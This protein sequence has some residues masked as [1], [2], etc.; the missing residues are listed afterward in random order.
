MSTQFWGVEGIESEMEYGVAARHDREV[1]IKVDA[2]GPSTYSEI[3][4]EL[5]TW[6][7]GAGG[8]EETGVVSSG[9]F[10]ASFETKLIGRNLRRGP[11]RITEETAYENGEVTKIF[12]RCRVQYVRYRANVRQ[13]D[14]R[15]TGYTIGDDAYSFS[16]TGAS[17][18][19]KFAIDVEDFDG[20]IPEAARKLVG[21]DGGDGDEQNIEGVDITIPSLQ[22][23]QR[24]YYSRANPFDS[25]ANI[26]DYVKDTV[27]YTGTIN[28]DVFSGF[29]AGELIFRGIQN[30]EYVVDADEDD[31]TEVTYVFEALPNRS[32]LEI[33]GVD[34][35]GDTT[36]WTLDK[37]GWNVISAPQ[38]DV[39][40]NGIVMPL[41]IGAV[42][43]QVSPETNFNAI[44]PS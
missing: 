8:I 1:T 6:L 15:P 34:A 19:V 9:A 14:D 5:D 29:A 42:S 12:W 40:V 28:N 18:N 44:Y 41:A 31:A 7:K 26:L 4:S 10:S 25:M 38:K 37:K 11:V 23:V 2:E 30:L 3:H 43:Q 22:I 27:P 16:T 20:N 13:A 32:G 35:N 39:V 24:K 33:P 17:R 36:V 21:W